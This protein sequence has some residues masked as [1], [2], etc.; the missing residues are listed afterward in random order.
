MCTRFHQ[1]IPNGRPSNEKC[2]EMCVIVP[3]LPLQQR[4]PSSALPGK[5]NDLKTSGCVNNP[6]LII[7]Y[8]FYD[9][10]EFL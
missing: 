2:K 1:K 9:F 7:L 6:P 8:K 3:E 10:R 5:P 4:K